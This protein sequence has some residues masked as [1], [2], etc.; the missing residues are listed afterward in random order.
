M[1]VVVAV[2]VVVGTMPVK[3]AV[4]VVDDER[5]LLIAWGGGCYA[6]GRVRVGIVGSGGAWSV[7]MTAR[8]RHRTNESV[9]SVAVG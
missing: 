5:A 9:A 4:T 3:R 2:V 6:G 8:V 7:V 1:A